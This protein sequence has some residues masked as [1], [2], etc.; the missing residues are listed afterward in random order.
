[1]PCLAYPCYP[2]ITKLPVVVTFSRLQKIRC[3]LFL[4]SKF[5]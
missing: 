2:A 4:I 1:M 3:Y 5:G